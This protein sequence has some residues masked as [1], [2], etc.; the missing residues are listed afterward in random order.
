MPEVTNKAK[1]QAPP[2]F[3]QE[4]RLPG[5][6]RAVGEN[7]ARQIREANLY[8]QARDESGRRQHGK[9]CQAVHISLFFYGTNNNEKSDTQKGQHINI[10]RTFVKTDRF[11]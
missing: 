5:T 8:K 11:S 2:A 1:V 9:C 3:P 10:T 4:G 6:S 7:Y